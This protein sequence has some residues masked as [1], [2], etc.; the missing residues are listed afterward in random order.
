MLLSQVP[1][2]LITGA[3]S[4][5]ARRYR[6]SLIGG[7]R[8]RDSTGTDGWDTNGPG[9]RRGYWYNEP[10][11]LATIGGPKAPDLYVFSGA[12]EAYERNDS[13]SQKQY[14][15]ERYNG[16]GWRV[17]EMLARLEDAP[18]FYIDGINRVRM[19]RFY[20]NRVVLVGDSAYGNTLGGFG[21]GLAVVGAYVLA[22][23][24]LTPG[25]GVMRALG[26]YDSIMRRYAKIARSG[27]AGPFLAPPSKLGIRLRDLSFSNRVLFKSMM[28]ITD[29]FATNIQLPE[30]NSLTHA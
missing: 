19:D 21:T 20:R 2:S 6:P 18:D 10:G 22:G 12:P 30:Y 16:M 17:P 4:L 9:R 11:R 3:F 24:L 25:A 13:D 8:L 15:S 23:E 29:I 27:N 7:S 14:I 26:N 28:K 1:F 5:S